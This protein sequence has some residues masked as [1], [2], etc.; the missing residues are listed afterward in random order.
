MITRHFTITCDKCGHDEKYEARETAS[1]TEFTNSNGWK[2][3]AIYL[4]G[5]SS[6]SPADT[7]DICPD[8]VDD[9][10]NWISTKIAKKG[11]KK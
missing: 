2:R 6:M 1:S 3:I 8:C 5:A 9:I 10:K 11:K 4:H 7:A